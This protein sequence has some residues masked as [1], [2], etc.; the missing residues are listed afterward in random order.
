MS[1]VIILR[2]LAGGPTL[3]P[4]GFN[5]MTSVSLFAGIVGFREV[6]AMA[7]AS[8]HG[9]PMENSQCEPVR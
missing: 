7:A 8:R 5:F 9:A 4:T 1:V 6:A 3:G 2:L